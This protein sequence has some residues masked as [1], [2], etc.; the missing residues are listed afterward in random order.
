MPKILVI[1][2]NS[3][4]AVT[5]RMEA[6]LV[7]LRS[8]SSHQIRC[9]E[10]AESPPGIETDEHVAAVIP[11]IVA[12]ANSSDA[13]AIVI[14]C[15]SDPGIAQVRNAVQVPVFGIAESSYLTA[16]SL[17]KKFGVI[18][19]GQSSID[20]HLRYLQ[21]LEIVGRLAGDRSINKTVVQ[22]LAEDVV[23]VVSKTAELLI[24]CDDAE[25]IV[26]GCAGLGNYRKALQEKLGVPVIDPVQAGVS[27]ATLTL[28]LGYHGSRA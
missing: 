17:G 9:I 10:L 8:A 20:R 25:V 6:A 11:N 5:K 1:N 4:E 12:A 23:E 22:L 27:L 24:E 19:L 16:L 7:G 13:D 18:S 3:S 2:P 28:D 21:Q 14:A 15:F 26:L